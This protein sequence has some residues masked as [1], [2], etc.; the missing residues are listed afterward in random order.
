[1]TVDILPLPT[2]GD[3]EVV[4][5]AT[6][7][8]PRQLVGRGQRGARRRHV[9]ADLPRPP[10]ARRGTRCERR[11]GSL[12]GRRAL[13]A[14][15]RG[16][17]RGVRLRVLRAPGARPGARAS[18]GGSTS[19]APRPGSKHWWV[20]SLTAPTVEELARGERRVVL[21]GDERVAVKDPVITARRRQRRVG[22]VAV[23]P[24][25]DRARPR[26][27]DDHPPPG[28]PDGLA[29]T[30]T[31]EVLAGRPGSGTSAAPGS[32]PCS[33]TTR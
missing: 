13:R 9:L 2:Y 27:P 33:P 23:L 30:D 25:A 8:R 20:D 19:P 5:P 31:G 12:R 32:P 14:R 29:W 18:A 24:P 22:D 28:E 21:P 3:A 26:G 4:V 16:V 7:R 15:H 6:G 11:G 10:T 17:P 1:M